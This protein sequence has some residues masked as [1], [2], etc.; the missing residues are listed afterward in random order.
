MELQNDVWLETM[1]EHFEQFTQDGKMDSARAVIATV[2]DQG[3]ESQAL[4]M[5]IEL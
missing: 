1:H 3:F 5:E 2:R 4:E